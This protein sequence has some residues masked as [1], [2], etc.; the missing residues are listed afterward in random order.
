[1]PGPFSLAL[2]TP[3]A[4]TPSEEIALVRMARDREGGGAYTLKLAQLLQALH[5]DG[6]VIELLSDETLDRTHAHPRNM[7]LGLSYLGRNGE[8]DAIAARRPLEKAVESAPGQLARA[9]ALSE[10]GKSHLLS[11]HD[12]EA[13]AALDAALTEDARTPY[14]FSRITTLDLRE[15]RERELLDRAESTLADGVADSSV[16]AGRYLALSALSRTAAAADFE[17]MDDLLWEGMLQPP[18]GWNS[19]D[20]FNAALAEEL[21]AHPGRKRPRQ[22]SEGNARWRVD[23]LLLER[24]RVVPALLTALRIQIEKQVAALL[25]RDHIWCQARPAHA[26]LHAWSMTTHD[27]AFDAWHMHVRGWMSGVYYVQIPDRPQGA[28]SGSIEF[29]CPELPG[30]ERTFNGRRRRIQPWPGQ[31]LLFPSHLYHRT[32]PTGSP[33]KR[34]SVA[35]DIVPDRRPGVETA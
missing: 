12:H 18:E 27:D 35:F 23:N 31:L 10:L 14:G 29:G 8:G 20:A 2:P 34:I 32:L 17:A 7:L 33:A 5:R 15:H 21:L 24:S 19:L 13:R 6:E 26:L 11:G 22:G 28:S 30:V 1:M 25:G 3:K 16:L 4:L 9:A